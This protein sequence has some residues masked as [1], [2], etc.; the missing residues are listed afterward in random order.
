MLALVWWRD[1][2]Q[3]MTSHMKRSLHQVQSITGQPAPLQP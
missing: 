3:K 1:G 2:P